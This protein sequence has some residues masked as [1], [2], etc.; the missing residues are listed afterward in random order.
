MA[1]SLSH[2][3][4]GATAVFVGYSSAVVLILEA[5]K[6]LDGSPA[7]QSSWLLALGLGMGL[8][9]LFLAFRY[10]APILTA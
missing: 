6:T 1:L 2:I 8:S 7:L 4:A 5:V 3:S 10:K 9:T